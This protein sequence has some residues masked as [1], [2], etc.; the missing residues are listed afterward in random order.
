MSKKTHVEDPPVCFEATIKLSS[1]LGKRLTS[2]AIDEGLSVEDYLSELVAEGAV[3]RAWE[4]AERKA[5]MKR[6]DTHHQA[7]RSNGK[8]DGQKF[9]RG[10]RP[11]QNYNS[12]MSDGANF[13]E[14]VR[15]QERQQER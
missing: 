9:S 15:E 13:L 2:Q 12:I 11:R 4:I 8:R 7:S 6:P 14:Y 10:R 1:A 3:V 5:Q